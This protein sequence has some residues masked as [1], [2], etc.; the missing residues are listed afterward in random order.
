MMK[1]LL[2]LTI[3][4]L[5]LV[6]CFG[7]TAAPATTATSVAKTEE[8]KKEAAPKAEAKEEPADTTP[9]KFAIVAPMTGNNAQFGQAYKYACQMLIDDVN[10]NGGINGHPVELEVFDDKNDPKESVNV[11]NMI[12]SDPAFLGVIGSQTSSCSM[13]IAPIFEDEGITMIS[14]SASHP[15]LVGIGDYIFR[16]TLT[17]DLETKEYANFVINKLGKKSFAI[18]YS[19]DD[20]GVALNTIFTERANEL[21]AEVKVA[22]T[23]VVN[24]TK[25]FSSLISK[26]KESGAECLFLA[27]GYA[28]TAQILQQCKNLEYQPSLIYGNAMWFDQQLLDIVGDNA[29]GLVFCANFDSRSSD[30]YF[31]AFNERLQKEHNMSINQYIAQS[32]DAMKL[33][34]D[35][36][37]KVGADRAKIRDEIAATKDFSGLMGTFSFDP[38]TREPN[39]ELF[40]QIIEKGEFVPYNG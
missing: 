17:Q 16:I 26:C 32:H 36:V 10:N 6:A 1:K 28:E 34:L 2:A 4:V 25:D 5:M 31:V 12:I 27:A 38:E 35:A 29:E 23:F 9:Y 19:N 14:P 21:G 3:A 15:D 33:F 40:P 8:V 18:I 22:E 37:E 13:A 11:A 39:R 24:Q 20:W 30:P 7:C